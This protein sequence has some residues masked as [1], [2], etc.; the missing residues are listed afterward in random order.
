MAK[1]I[2]G[3]PVNKILKGFFGINTIPA[4][5]IFTP[6]INIYDEMKGRV[7]F[8]ERRDGWWNNFTYTTQDG[9]EV[10]VVETHQGNTIVD[11]ILC[12][13]DHCEYLVF[14]GLCGGFHPEMKIGD[15]TIA[16][17][18][19]FENEDKYYIPK[20]SLPEVQSMFPTAI[21]GTN[22]T[23]ESMIR[24]T[25][26]VKSNRP[27]YLKEGTM[28]VDQETAYLYRDATIPASSIMV[29]SD[30]PLTKTW[31]DLGFFEKRQI[32]KGIKTLTDGVLKLMDL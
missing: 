32:Q 18:S 24:E 7:N 6:I 19:Y 20:L 3:M 25:I 31:F 21:S 28:S 5:V 11:S 30:L 8:Q 29:V 12:V 27:G 26:A 14:C 16:T 13:N 4:K 2:A 22:L 15:I 10:V 23:V 9:Q 17:K 1:T